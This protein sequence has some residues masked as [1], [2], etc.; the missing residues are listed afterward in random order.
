MEKVEAFFNIAGINDRTT[1]VKIRYALET[2]KNE[3]IKII[4]LFI[5]FALFDKQFEFILA[6]ALLIPIRVFSGG[7][8]MNT[9]LGC[10]LYSL[11]F[12]IL[13]IFLLPELNLSLVTH[14]YILIISVSVMAILSP[15][16]SYKRP[17]KTVARRILMK[18]LTLI[19][20]A[21]VCVA[22][23]LIWY[24]ADSIN[25][26]IGTWVVALQ[27]IQLI[28]IWVYRKKKGEKNVRK[29]QEVEAIAGR[30]SSD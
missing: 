21:I 15:I 28:T 13:S 7:M 24:F 6:A 1:I 14:I 26:S 9:N 23:I 22:L 19:V 10:F 29:D 2:I 5:L 20:L 11:I 3:G 30:D 27:S 16:P 25:F 12:F 18:K 17:F 4:I 8:H